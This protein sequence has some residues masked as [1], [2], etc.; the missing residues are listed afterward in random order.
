ML[1]A[2]AVREFLKELD[3]K[4][5]SASFDWRYFLIES[6]ENGVLAYL[7]IDF[8]H[9]VAY[10][11]IRLIEEAKYKHDALKQTYS[12]RCYRERQRKYLDWL[13]KRMNKPG[14]DQLGD[15]LEFYG[16]FDYRG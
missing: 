14:W 10:G 12:Y 15:R 6:N 4:A 11:T 13:S 7:S 16:D 8:L 5:G 3:G 2:E 1:C 9:E